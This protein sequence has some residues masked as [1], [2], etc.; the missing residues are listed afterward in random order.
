M[1]KP[2]RAALVKQPRRVSLRVKWMALIAGAVFISLLA[3][4]VMLFVTVKASLSHAFSQAN[5]VQVESATREM[6]MFSEQ[7]E[8]LAE[9]M[10]KEIV[11]LRQYS[12]NQDQAIDQLLGETQGKDSALTAVSF[13]LAA[14]GKQHRYP[15]TG[16]IGDGREEATYKLVQASHETSWTDV[17]QDNGSAD[18]I[19]SVAVPV[20][21]DDKLY[22]VVGL[23]IDLKGI[24]SL[25]ESNERFGNNKLV[26]YDNQGLIV[27]SFMSEMEGKN[28]DPES[29]RKQAGIQDAISDPAKMKRSFG[30]VR[31]IMNGKTDGIPFYWEGRTY[32]GEVSYVYSL[33]W[34]VVSFADKKQLTGS[35]LDF[36]QTSVIALVIGL[37]IGGL[38]AFYIATR[39][40]NT[41]RA[42]RSTIAKTAGGDLVTPF[43]YDGNDEIGDLA[44]D[45]NTMLHSI[46]ALIR[47]VDAGVR[48]VEMSAREVSRIA[49]ENAVTGIEV[50]RS[51]EEIAL[52]ASNT[53][54]EVEKSTDAVYRLNREIGGLS[55]QS[56]IIEGVL[57]ESGE[58]VARG[59][60]QAVNLEVSYGQVALAF[61]EVTRM[62][63]DLNEKS[64][65]ISSVIRAISEIAN[66]TN[67]LSINASIEAA[68]AGIHGKGFAV[69]AEEVRA[70][71][72]QARR[73]AEQIQETITA[74]LTQTGKL[75][76]VVS[77]T[78]AVNG[79][80][81]HAVA[82][83]GDAM[84]QVNASLERML[85]EVKTEMTAI[86]AIESQKEVVAIVMENISSVSEETSASAQEIA[87][88]VEEQTDSLQKVSGHA[89]RLVELV[90]DLKDSVSKFRVEE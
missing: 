57:A 86:A 15:A 53:S 34:T 26:I 44:T 38:A 50:A 82:H 81:K 88:S 73:S 46:R 27:S 2:A 3:L 30:W 79:T 68:R 80:Q 64:K 65:S 63:A 13:T 49:E 67:I 16:D 74:V 20:M 87:S 43:Q 14:T 19:V 35:L 61:E 71:A 78:N 21:V 51:T 47:K 48:S 23:N 40:L 4:A 54:L 58:H 37:A 72:G 84:K 39:L 90:R 59:N 75:V 25:R 45:Y 10:G 5:A 55:E 32:T 66:E 29:A 28:I 17:H 70:L 24:G 12:E 33:N 36:L 52:G 76:E 42:L 9:Q 89:N 83:V 7:Y 11:V 62:V 77:R 8:K 60:A 41:I 31:T 85:V 22:G 6:R 69:I 1:A 56:K 18:L